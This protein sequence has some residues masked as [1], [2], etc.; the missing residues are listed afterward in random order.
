MLLDATDCQPHTLV[1]RTW[2]DKSM[3]PEVGVTVDAVSS[4]IALF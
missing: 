4:A 2:G 3:H 1:F